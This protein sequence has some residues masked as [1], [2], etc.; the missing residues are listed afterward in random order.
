MAKK[1]PNHIA[2]P[3]G[4]AY[5][6]WTTNV[7]HRK[8]PGAISA[9]ALTVTPVNPKVGFIF[10]SVDSAILTPLCLGSGCALL[11]SPRLVLI[12]SPAD[13]SCAED[14]SRNYATSA[15]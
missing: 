4:Y 2:M 11:S 3:D 6:A 7:I 9:I 8:A 5:P 12:S 1:I 14:G 10:G 13:L 15:S